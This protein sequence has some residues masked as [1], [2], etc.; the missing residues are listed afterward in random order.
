[1]SN[2]TKLSGSSAV[3][4]DGSRPLSDGVASPSNDGVASPS[5]GIAPPNGGVS[6]P[7]GDVSD[8]SPPLNGEVSPALVVSSREEGGSAAWSALIR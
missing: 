6:L 7:D 1:M 5:N 4:G 8:V 2:G 3:L